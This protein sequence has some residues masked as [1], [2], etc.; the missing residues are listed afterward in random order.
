MRLLQ[1]ILLLAVLPI[2]IRCE[3]QDDGNYV[4]PITR[5]ELIKG[6]WKLNSI[7]MVDEL[8]KANNQKPFEMALTSE[9][10]FTTMVIELKVDSSSGSIKPTGFEVTGNAPALFASSGYW[11]MD[12]P[13]ARSDGKASKIRLYSDKAKTQLLDELELT[14]VPGKENKLEFRLVRYSEGNPYLSY[15]YSF[16]P[17]K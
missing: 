15:T 9:F 7:K 5:Y 13:Y 14:A 17:I 10:N 4:L 1:R 16:K 8:A 3:K 12:V 11:D 2:L 6:K